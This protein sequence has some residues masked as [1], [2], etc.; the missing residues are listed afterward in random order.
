MLA[1]SSHEQRMR[2]LN[3]NESLKASLKK[4]QDET[5]VETDSLRQEIRYV[6]KL[7]YIFSFDFSFVSI[8]NFILNDLFP[9]SIAISSL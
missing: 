2:L 9:C 8:N 5:Q 7:G 4:L 1:R 3:A 6:F